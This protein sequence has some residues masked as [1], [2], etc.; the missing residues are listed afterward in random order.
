MKEFQ[1]ILFPVSLTKI[2]PKVAPYVVSMAKKYDAE[3]HLLH[4]ARAM[5]QYVDTY[6]DQPSITEFKKL[7]SNF[8]KELSTGAE[9]RLS[10][11]R[12]KYFKGISNIKSTVLS[13]IHYKEIMKY[14]E[15][16]SMDLIIMGTGGGV[17]AAVFGSVADKV[18][19][20]APVPVMLIKTV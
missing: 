10:T 4:I 19:K 1:K 6:I 3:I 5:D 16:N 9:T 12:E 20:I 14:V 2:S 13:G 18:A 15:S 8:E 11:F 7:A 17:Y